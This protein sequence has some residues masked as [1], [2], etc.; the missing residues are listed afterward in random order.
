MNAEGARKSANR[1]SHPFLAATPQV[2]AHCSAGRCDM[3]ILYEDASQVFAFWR[4]PLADAAALMPDGRLEPM[5]VFGKAIAGFVAFEY[6]DTSAGA[7][8]EIGLVILVRRRQTSPSLWRLLRHP[9][10]EPDAGFYVVNL[11]VTTPLAR[12]AGVEFWGYPKY[13]K[14][15]PTHFARESVH[16]ELDGELTFD[17]RSGHGVGVDAFTVTTFSILKGKLIHTVIPTH[18]RLRFGGAGSVVLKITGDGPAA[19][20]VQALGM[21]RSR[22]L[23]VFRNDALRVILPYG[24]AVA[25]PKRSR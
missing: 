22:P 3:P 2:E 11:P 15:I 18:G 17:H 14:P 25:E 5:P 6:R 12:A 20:T 16:I 8:N 21:D 9:E 19:R 4:V 1:Y 7:Y 23:A 24:E 13:V 10:R